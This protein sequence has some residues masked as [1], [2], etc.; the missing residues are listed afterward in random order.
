MSLPPLRL[1]PDFHERVW[2]G[3][4]LKPGAP[5]IGEAWIVHEG[6]RVAGGP[7]AGRTL[8]E[9]AEAEGPALL[10]RRAGAQS[11]GR[12]PL[13]I[14]LLDC[15]D[16]LS[17]QVH[18]NDEQAARL[19][20]PGQFGKT[21]AWHIL[22]AAPDARVISGLRPGTA[23]AQ[24]EQAVRSGTLLEWLEYLPVKNGDTLFTP[25]GLLHA[26]GP[27][28]LLYEVQQ[29]SDITYRVFDWN[30][31]ASAGRALH[32]EQ[33]LAVTAVGLAGQASAEPSLPDGGRTTLVECDYFALDLMRSEARPVDLDTSGDS[34]HALTL[35][36]GAGVIAAPAWSEPLAQFETLVVPASAGPYRLEPRGACRALL[37][38]V[39]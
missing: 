30:R 31:P 35:V 10:G 32:V 12:F 22:E 38:R 5:S 14:K 23:P 1:Q 16:W 3:A 27:G 4:R 34:F 13:L 17:V 21:E 26:L 7:F 37:S 33:S 8:A 29:T 15:H 25:A 18:P 9:V 19:E 20:G 2:G 36:E 24:F 6:N 28:L 11:D 39:P